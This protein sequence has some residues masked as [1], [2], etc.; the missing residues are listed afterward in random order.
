[1]T[2]RELHGPLEPPTAPMLGKLARELRAASGAWRA[3]NDGH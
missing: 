3:E 2:P 1:M